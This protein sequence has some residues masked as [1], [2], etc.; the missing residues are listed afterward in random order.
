MVD[1]VFERIAAGFE[2]R[3]FGTKN[4]LLAAGIVDLLAAGG[5]FG[6]DV[7]SPVGEVLESHLA[8]AQLFAQLGANLLEALRFSLGFGLFSGGAFDVFGHTLLLGFDLSELVTEAIY[9][10]KQAEDLLAIALE[11]A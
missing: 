4:V 2:A 9:F 1:D 11:L 10:A 6:L 5:E 8:G 3:S 7:L